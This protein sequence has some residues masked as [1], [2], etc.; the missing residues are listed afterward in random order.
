M[1]AVYCQ[2]LHVRWEDRFLSHAKAVHACCIS[3]AGGCS[4][5]EPDIHGLQVDRVCYRHWTMRAWY[6][7][8]VDGD[9][10]CQWFIHAVEELCPFDKCI[11]MI[12]LRNLNAGIIFCN[13]DTHLMP[14]R[15]IDPCWQRSP[16]AE[17]T[18]WIC[19]HCQ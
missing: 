9:I 2:S 17:A 1:S 14:A 15:C 5:C 18:R 6:H 16:Y 13:R 4:F 8:I 12:I 3:C 7:L 10:K 19:R 11:A